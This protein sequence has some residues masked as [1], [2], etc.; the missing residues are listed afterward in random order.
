MCAGVELQEV[1]LD[2]V[3][4][5]DTALGHVRLDLQRMIGRD[6]P[7]HEGRGR[8]FAREWLAN[9]EE[10]VLGIPREARSGPGAAARRPVCWLLNAAATAVAPVMRLVSQPVEPRPVETM[11]PLEE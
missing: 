2:A 1:G 8:G 9:S 4:E 11:T 5:D 7:E 6:A 10:Q 3:A